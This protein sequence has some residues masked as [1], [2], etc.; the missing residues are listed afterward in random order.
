MKKTLDKLNYDNSYTR[1]PDIFYTRHKPQALKNQHL[2]HI[3]KELSQLIELDPQLDNEQRFLQQITDSSEIEDYE[4]IAQ[5]YAG[6]QFG[7]FVPRL[8]D[9]R[10]MLL[11]EIL[12]SDNTRWD[13]QLK[14]A[15]ITEYSRGGDGR[16]VLRSTIRE[17]LCSEAMHGLGIP[18]TRALCIIG[19]DEDVYREK[20]ESGAMLVRVAQSHIRFGTFEYFYYSNK[21]DEIK[22]MADYVIDLHF[23]QL[24]QAQNPYLALLEN[25]IQSTA[26]LIA[27]WQAVGFC[28]GVMNTDNMSIH[29]LTLDYGPYAFMDQFDRDYICNHSDHQG[30]YAYKK[31]P[32]AGLFNVSC[33]A[34]T[35]LPVLHEDAKKAADIAIQALSQ[36]QHA[37]A[38]EY[39]SQMRKK[40][41]FLSTKASDQTLC[42]D[43]LDIMQ[44]QKIDY[45]IF[46]RGISQVNQASVADL[47]VNRAIFEAWFVRYRDRLKEDA[48]S[49]QQRSEKQ[50]QVNPN[51]ILR[52]Y[53]AENAIQKANTGDYSEIDR[54]FKV[55]KTPFEEKS[56]YADYAAQ[57]P[58]WAN[59]ISISCSS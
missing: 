16:A 25:V 49:E 39:A 27:N 35:L 22:I 20:I 33:F 44:Q 40:L 23:P 46:F 42:N 43:L 48:Q 18:T 5:C 19:S 53:M 52:N 59:E 13:L 2:I 55:L 11:G 41:G 34:Q 30:R 32:E 8:G 58:A 57:V 17:Y 29:G 37:Y 21:L 24:R 1:L 4:C 26:S 10:A 31:Q 6:H 51:Y 9:G 7:H 28:H 12:T 3:N 54:L 14:G 45:S 36:Y 56:E 15:G 38:Q 47:F 50:K